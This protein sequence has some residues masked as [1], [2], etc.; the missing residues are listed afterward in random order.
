MVDIEWDGPEA[1]V[2]TDWGYLKPVDGH[3]EQT[4][5]EIKRPSRRPGGPH[6]RT[7]T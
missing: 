1:Q 6:F 2:S 3:P 5:I 7:H 4:A